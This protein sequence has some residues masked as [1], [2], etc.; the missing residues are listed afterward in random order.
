MRTLGKTK[1]QANSIGMG[2]WAIGGPFYH[3][4]GKIISYGQ[5]K[6]SESIKALEKGIEMGVNLFDTANNYGAGRS[7]RVLGSVLKG[8]RE[9]FIIATKFGTVWDFN[10]G[11]SEVPQRLIGRDLSKQGIRK[12]CETSLINLQTDYIDFYQ[13]HSGNMTSE[14][15]TDVVEI[16][17]ELVDEGK[18]LYYG[19]STDYPE[20]GSLLAHGKHFSGMQFRLNMIHSN[21][22]MLE[23]LEEIQGFGLIKNPLSGGLLSGKYKDDSILPRDHNWHGSN[24][25]EGRIG[26]TRALL[27]EL[28]VI[29]ENEDRTLVQASLGYI[30]AKNKNIIPIPGFKTVEQAEE[31]SKVIEMGPLSKR[32]VDEIDQLFAEIRRDQSEIPT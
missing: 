15:A 16:L 25:K 3:S 12:A 31:N 4:G 26:Q 22:K 27:D 19:W 24:F 30:L 1:L 17:E 28:K 6:D 29:L 7:E 8:R 10:S 23:F 11:D 14:E 5:V 2:C 18:I 20:R 21:T 32:L 9:D 13:V